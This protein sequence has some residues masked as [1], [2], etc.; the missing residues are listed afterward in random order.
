MNMNYYTKYLKYKNKYLK[1]KNQIGGEFKEVTVEY[2]G[3]N[4]TFY[5]PSSFICCSTL[6]LMVDPVMTSDN[7]IYERAIIEQWLSTH[8]TSPLTN[9]LLANKHL[10]PVLAFKNAIKETIEEEYK[11]QLEKEIGELERL[12]NSG[13]CNAQ[14]ELALK[15][16]YSNEDTLVFKNFNKA[17]KLLKESSNKCK[18]AKELIESYDFKESIFQEGKRLYKEK[19]YSD[20]ANMWNEATLLKHP[21]SYAFLSDMLIVGRLGVSIDKKRAFQLAKEGTELGSM[22]SKGALGRCYIE[23]IGVDKNQ[24]NMNIGLELAK[25]SAETNSC[26]GQFTL[27]LCYEE[28]LGVQQETATAIHWYNLA[29]IQGY[30]TAQNNLA[31]L[32]YS[33][34]NYEEAFKWFSLSAEQGYSFAQYY[35]GNAYEYGFGVAPDPLKAIEWYRLA[36]EQGDIE[37]QYRLGIKFYYGIDVPK[38]VPESIRWYRLAAEQDFEPAQCELG[39]IFELSEDIPHDYA[40][41]MHFYRLAA[42]HENS[43]AIYAL[44]RMFEHGRGVT[45]DYAEAVRLYRLAAEEK[46]SDAE[47]N[48]GRMYEHGLGVPKDTVEADRW[49]AAAKNHY[50]A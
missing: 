12:S 23:G 5:V 9:E 15:Y 8:N 33:D 41:A 38:N 26:F 39:R 21:D 10:R 43:E 6:D 27:G 35:L 29:A 42:A 16:Y 22:D 47:F 49:Y 11:K 30:A 13:D 17:I 3:K 28:G 4:I 40:Q 19:K 1:I 31:Y 34:Q 25:E 46:N 32:F 14:F 7:H 37:S 48:L 20:A 50:F 36:A 24:E 44:G 18:S 2:N 45:Q